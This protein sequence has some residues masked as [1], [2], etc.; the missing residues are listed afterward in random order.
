MDISDVYNNKKVD[1]Q[2]QVKGLAIYCRSQGS[3][4]VIYPIVYHHQK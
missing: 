4:F 1:H 2:K 3:T